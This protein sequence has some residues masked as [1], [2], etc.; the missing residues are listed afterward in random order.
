MGSGRELALRPGCFAL[1]AR[2]RQTLR[3][4]GGKV[5]GLG[6]AAVLCYA[7]ARHDEA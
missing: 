4:N 7:F 5:D 1:A 6:P 2:S 3:L